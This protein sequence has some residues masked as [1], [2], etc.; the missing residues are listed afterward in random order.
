MLL[1]QENGV[2]VLNILKALHFQA[3][4]PS[5][6]PFLEV[7]LKTAP[8]H[9]NS[10]GRSWKTMETAREQKGTSVILNGGLIQ[11]SAELPG[12]SSEMHVFNFELVCS[13][14]KVKHKLK[15]FVGSE[16]GFISMRNKPTMP[17]LYWYSHGFL[18][19]YMH[20]CKLYILHPSSGQ[21]GHHPQNLP[22]VI[23]NRLG[24]H[25]AKPKC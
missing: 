15:G 10:K 11:P 22:G 1:R 16:S 13:P 19:A 18:L 21:K 12:S 9:G 17:L 20:S 25:T 5:Q 2:K 14:I 23:P 7:C 6:C 24:S 4:L 8:F 3:H